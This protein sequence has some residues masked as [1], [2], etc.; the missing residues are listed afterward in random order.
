[1]NAFSV[2]ACVLAV[3]VVLGGAGCARVND[4]SRSAID[5][6]TPYRVEVVQGNFVSSEQVDALRPGMGRAQV[7]EIL[8][9]PLLTSVF[10]DARWDYVFTIRRQGVPEQTRRLSVFFDGDNFSHTTGDAL[11]SEEEFVA[12]IARPMPTS[13][14]P[15]LQASP[16]QLAAAAARSDK[17]ATIAPKTPTAQPRTSYPPLE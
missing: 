1:M 16:E 7:R 4:L 2:R 10:H 14:A 3:S 12:T 11:P 17:P 9:S 5:A 8:G 15:T 13:A 6:V